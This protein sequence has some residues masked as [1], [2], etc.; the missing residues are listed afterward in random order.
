[1]SVESR[2]WTKFYRPDAARGEIRYPEVPVYRLLEERARQNPELTALAFYGYTVSYGELVAQ[3]NRMAR[4]FLALGLQKGDRVM[5]MLPNCPAYV[6]A[7]YGALKAGG[8]VAQVNPLYVEREIVHIAND[9]EARFIV[10]A[11]LLYG[12]VRQALPQTKL[13]RVI[14]A[15]LTGSP[16]IG[17]E[18][19]FLSQLMAEQPADEPGVE[20]D[21][22]DVAVLQYTGGT[23]GM[24]KGAMLTH[25]NLVANVVQ[26]E[27][28]LQPSEPG[29]VRLMTIL[30]LFHSYGMTCCMNLGL[31]KG[32]L[33]V[34]L[35]RFEID[36][37][38]QAIRDWKVTH[39]PGVPT[40]H[41]AVL[42]YP[43]AEAYGIEN[44]KQV[45]SGGAAM[46]VEVA[47][48]YQ[49]R[50][51]ARL[52]EGYGLSEASP[53]THTTPTWRDGLYKRGSIG[54]PLPDTDVRIVDLE[55][56]TRVLG[57]GEEGEL[58]IAGPQVMR[59]YW[60]RPEETAHALREIDGKTWLYT[61]DVAKMDEEGR[62]YILDRKKEMIL[63]GGYNVY[64][65][66]IEEALY[67]HPAVLEA[68]AIGVHDAYMGE[69]VK[70]F[71]ALKPGMSAEPEELIEH[72][73]LHLAP[74]KVPRQIEIRPGLPKSAVGKVLRRELAHEERLKLH[75][76]KE[77]SAHESAS[78]G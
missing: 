10:T 74:F 67:E 55:S 19:V 53:V 70:A 65:R 68:A 15:E 50:F 5:L 6:V 60:R 52:V 45:S 12:K 62:F 32:Y 71:V 42:N 28:M 14:L 30:P 16:A 9:S 38:M 33:L 39:F 69:V 8:I 75:Q 26:T 56:G 59:G 4:A 1:M 13:E 37:V 76:Q 54:V 31:W 73:R 25:F 23:T 66:E 34:L 78:A 27:A 17:P 35:P 40:M 48:A 24:P 29:E 57:P 64:P 36:Q 21:P 61:G 18:A 51:T 43:D 41:V 3:V 20:V 7:Y 72:C 44:L 47:E 22:Q 63:V 58:I 2:P 49:Q 11:D 77:V 46:P